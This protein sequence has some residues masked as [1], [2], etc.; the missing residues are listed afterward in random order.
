MN[1]D[2]APASAATVPCPCCNEPRTLR[3]DRTVYCYRT[4]RTWTIV[5]TT[6]EIT[7]A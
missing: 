3:T 1:D 5:T 2:R 7:D 4:Q 6:T